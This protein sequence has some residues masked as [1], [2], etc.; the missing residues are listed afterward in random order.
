M[1]FSMEFNELIEKICKKAGISEEKAK[2]LVEEKKAKFAGLLTDTGAAYLVAKELNIEIEEELNLVKI[3]ELKEGMR[4]IDVVARVKQVFP[5]RKF[6]SSKGKGKRLDLVVEDETSEIR[7]SLWHDDVKQIDEKQIEKGDVI[8][9]KN[10]YVK[11]YKEKPQLNLASSGVIE[12]NPEIEAAKNLVEEKKTKKLAELT[13]Q[14]TNVDVVVRIARIYSERSFSKETSGKYLPFEIVDDTAKKRAVAWN[15][16][17]ELIKPLNVGELVKI[18]NA[19][20]KDNNGEVELHLGYAARVIRDYN[21][22]LPE[23][24]SLLGTERNI[25][26]ISELAEGDKFVEIEGVIVDVDAPRFF[27]VCEKCGSKIEIVNGKT[28]CPRCNETTPIE[29]PIISMRIDD[30]SAQISSVC[31]GDD[32]ERLIAKIDEF[33]PEA[34]QKEPA[35]KLNEL[36]GKKINASGFVRKSSF[37][38]K[39]FV[40]KEAKIS[41]AK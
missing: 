31:F 20:T 4:N 35:T 13:A 1:S 32:A 18:E 9:I 29:K 40:I 7:L 36:V 33:V 8:L 22:E 27:S 19:Y 17:I 26:K 12:K 3:A 37:E 28:V 11:R 15:D 34:K 21:Y 39:E 16:A 30:G 10:C 38:E 24:H 5:L 25:K 41:A 23:L 14:E 2:E 6:E